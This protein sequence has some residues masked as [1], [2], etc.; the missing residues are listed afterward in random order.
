MEHQF[1]SFIVILAELFKEFMCGIAGF[2]GDKFQHEQLHR[3]G[4]SM[5]HRGPDAEG[6]YF[7]APIGFCHRRL[8]I[9]DQSD[10]AN[11]PF[12]FQDLVLI[13]NGEIYNYKEIRHQLEQKGY[14]FNTNSDTE[15]V[16]MAFDHWGAEMVHQ[17]NGMFA[18]AIWN[19]TT[20]ELSLFRDRAGVKPLFYCHFGHQFAFASEL[21]ALKVLTGD[22][23]ICQNG[24]LDY[25]VHGYTI[26]PHS[27]YKGV[28]KLEPG[29]YLT[30]NYTNNKLTKRQYWSI[31][32]FL[33]DPLPDLGEAKMLDQLEEILV[34]AFNYRMVSDVPV[35]VFLSGGIDST[36]VSAILRK[37]YGNIR[38]FTIG[39]DEE[40]FNEAP[41]AKQT[42]DYLGL[43]HTEEIMPL[44]EAANY[45]KQFYNTY[46]EPFHDASGIATSVVSK[47][48]KQNGIKVVL[49]ADGADELFCGY[50]NYLHCLSNFNK[51]GKI[52][53]IIAK[54]MHFFLQNTYQIYPKTKLRKLAQLVSSKNSS[55]FYQFMNSNGITHLLDQANGNKYVN[56]YLHNPSSVNVNISPL[57][58]FMAWDFSYLLPDD[59]LMKVDRATM[60]HSIEGREPFLDYKLIEFAMRLPVHYKYK[61]GQQKYLLKKLLERYV[62][63]SF[64][65]RPKKGFLV[66]LYKWFKG[67]FSDTLHTHLNEHE[68]N[69]AWPQ[70]DYSMIRQVLS[71]FDT[72]NLEQQLYLGYQAW[73]YLSLMLWTKQHYQN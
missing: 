63:N 19:K 20:N 33:N 66:P 5:Q 1:H 7:D 55:E 56:Q 27:I 59:M 54:P 28:S 58:H 9:I 39:F 32:P 30:Y 8:A 21:T 61:N 4:A 60:H 29:C 57:A 52:P 72:N 53:S 37:H 46:D 35:G 50:P 44:K 51:F 12:Y 10:E 36:L 68:F 47:L 65:Y 11:Q 24:L 38:T 67:E 26:A 70:I 41:H 40:S 42:A 2:L 34:E 17:F 48:A 49:S 43:D 14:T 16:I 71:H 45:F 73:K 64:I 15:V 13:Y 25:L 22:F 18:I 31:T 3:V 23:E 6:I 62:P 69:R